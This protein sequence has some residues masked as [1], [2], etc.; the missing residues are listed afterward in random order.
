MAGR[1]AMLIAPRQF[2]AAWEAASSK[3]GDG[4]GFVTAPIPHAEDSAPAAVGT[5]DYLMAF[6][7]GAAP[8]QDARNEAIASFLRFYYDSAETIEPSFKFLPAARP[9]WLLVKQGLIFAEQNALIG[10]EVRAEL[11]ALQMQIEE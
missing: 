3:S 9:E 8:D 2:P 7:D 1:L 5:L 6:R 11:D 4:V 10:G